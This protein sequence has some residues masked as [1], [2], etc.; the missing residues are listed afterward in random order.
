MPDASHDPLHIRRNFFGF[1]RKQHRVIKNNLAPIVHTTHSTVYSV[2]LAVVELPVYRVRGNELRVRLS[3]A[4]TVPVGHR[5]GRVYGQAD[6]S[7]GLLR[8]GSSGVHIAPKTPSISTAQDNHYDSPISEVGD[9]ALRD[10][11]S[12]VNLHTNGTEFYGNSSNL[13]FLGNL[14]AR[15]RSQADNRDQYQLADY[16]SQLMQETPANQRDQPPHPEPSDHKSGKSGK[17]QLSI[18]NLLYNADY[19]GH[20]S[21][22]SQSGG[23]AATPTTQ[24]VQSNSSGLLRPVSNS[25]KNHLEIIFPR[26][27]NNAQM[28]IEKIFIG[29]YFANKH[30]IH[31]I[32]S[33]SSFMRRC[34]VEAWPNSRRA[35]LFRGLTKFARLYFAVVALGAINASPDETSLLDHF[36]Q[37]TDDQTRG[38]TGGM[39]VRTAAAIGLGSSLSSLPPSARREARRTW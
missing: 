9:A 23:E 3:T 36:C 29:S 21:P 10:G 39:A 15:A 20:L 11:L 4:K 38:P 19:P 8:F 35:G 7:P 1:R 18:V 37:Q 33:K 27:T 13:A 24:S 34:E 31:P 6:W 32:L 2:H 16:V 26:L 28:E 12:G 14:Y 30:Y 25:Q 5:H 22:Q 17:S